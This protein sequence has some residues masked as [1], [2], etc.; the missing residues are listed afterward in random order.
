MKKTAWMMAFLIILIS[1]LPL[2]VQGAEL[3]PGGQLIGL[4]MSTEHATV[5]G[6]E[7]N[8][9]VA[10]RAGM[11]LGDTITHIDQKSVSCAA[12]IRTALNHSQGTITVGITRKGKP[13]RLSMNPAITADGP[14]IG[15]YLKQAVSGVGTV[16]YYDPESGDFGALG[17][18]VNDTNGKLLPSHGGNAYDASILQVRKGK[19]GKPGQLMGTM[20][21]AKILGSLGKNTQQGVFGSSQADFTGDLLETASASQIHTGSATI[22]ST[23]DENGVQE[24]SV[25]IL[26]IYPKGRSGG[27]NM[28]IQVTDQRLLDT[29]GGI[30]QGMSGSP[31]I[32]D[33]KLIGAVTH[34]LVN[35]PTMGYAIFIENMLEAAA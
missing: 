31:I 19:S 10:K 4:E 35:D 3:I 18:S 14:R 5:A 16:T 1:L 20:N 29:T 8:N 26:K 7:E 21:T 2:G 34:V 32:Q 22:R 13:M 15:V 9:P 24:Y 30:V 6:F 27:R 25:K 33:G 23:V 11:H 17:H 12:D 28:L